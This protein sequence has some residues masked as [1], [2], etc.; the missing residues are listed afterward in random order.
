MA[1]DKG[2]NFRETAGFVTDGAN[3]TYAI[4]SAETYPTTRN[5]VTFGVENVFGWSTRDRLDTNDRRL[6]GVNWRSD[7]GLF[8]VD[9]EAADDYVIDL[10][11]GDP[12]GGANN[13]DSKIYDNTTVLATIGPTT[14]GSG[15]FVDASGVNRTSAA[16][17]V[18]NRVTIQHTFATT[19]FFVS[20][21]EAASALSPLAHLFLSRVAAAGQT[22]FFMRRRG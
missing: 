14:N 17:W 18:S 22:D 9:L 7:K 11:Y 6:A 12:S 13:P 5:S 10:A 3:E 1:W 19:T 4:C 20:V 21:S 16:L 2:F 15:E 8:R